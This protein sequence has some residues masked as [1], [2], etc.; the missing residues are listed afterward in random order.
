MKIKA[1][2]SLFV[3]FALTACNKD[4]E[5]INTNPNAPND[6]QPSLL[7]RQVLFDYAEEM[8]YEGFVAGNLLSQSFTMIDF[9]LFDR[10]SLQDPQLGGN[11][12]PVIYTNLRDNE[13]ILE[14]SRASATNAVYEGPALILKAYMTAALTDIYGDV[15]YTQALQGTSGNVTPAY[16]K[17]EDIY[18]GTNG[19]LDNLNRGIAALEGYEGVPAFRRRYFV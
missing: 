18:R 10:H 13:L 1:L 15:P 12:W 19:I 16:D 2:L 7:L 6:V 4:F 14:R 8:S 3:V 17:Q 11:P 9:N 5:E